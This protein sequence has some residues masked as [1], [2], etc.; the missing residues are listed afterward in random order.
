VSDCERPF[1]SVFLTCFT[2]FCYILQGVGCR[3]HRVRNG[4]DV[5][6]KVKIKFIGSES[7]F[8]RFGFYF[9]DFGSASAIESL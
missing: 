2:F 7:P 5:K 9:L 8:F 3:R 6:V 4:C 1:Y